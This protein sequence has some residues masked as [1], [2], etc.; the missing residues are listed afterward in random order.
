MFR[1]YIRFN[2][3]A[4]V[5]RVGLYGLNHVFGVGDGLIICLYEMI[6]LTLKHSSAL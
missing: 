6:P 3:G 4:F 5:L 2:I 1:L